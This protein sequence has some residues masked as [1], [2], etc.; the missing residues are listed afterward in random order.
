MKSIQ[1]IFQNSLK[2]N[3]KDLTLIQELVFELSHKKLSKLKDERHIHKNIAKLYTMFTQSLQNENL[4]SKQ[5]T[6]EVINGILKA[7]NYRNESEIYQKFYERDEIQ[8]QIEQKTQQLQENVGKIYNTIAEISADDEAKSALEEAKLNNIYLSGI[9][10]EVTQEALVTTIEKGEDI[11]ET[12]SNVIKNLTFRSIRS[13][14]FRK[15]IFVTITKSVLDATIEISNIDQSHAKELLNGCIIGMKDGI[16]KAVEAFKNDIKFA[17]DGAEI[18]S[19]F[20]LNEANKE[21]NSIEEDFIA[22]LYQY[23]QNE[24]YSSKIIDEILKNELDSTSAKLTRLIFDAKEAVN[25]RM[26]ELKENTNSQLEKLKLGTGEFEKLATQKVE[27]LKQ[28]AGKFEKIA[29]KKVGELKLDA[30]ELEKIASKKFEE[31]RKISSTTQAKELGEKVWKGAKDFVKNA[32]DAL[33][34]K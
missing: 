18:L 19:M 24:N 34:K 2:E 26:Q 16:S 29:S 13:G 11:K 5:N 12:T 4:A 28:N 9:L 33:N 6:L 1:T 8:K 15:D 20:D 21:L 23:T 31:L 22:T 27:A 30:G 25:E 3:P 17:P 32:K 7:A 10:K 14:S